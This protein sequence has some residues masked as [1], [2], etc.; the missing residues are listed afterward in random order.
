MFAPTFSGVLVVLSGD[1]VN[2]IF[3]IDLVTFVK[4]FPRDSC[5]GLDFFTTGLISQYQPLTRVIFS[6]PEIC[7]KILNIF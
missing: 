7:G 1:V 5:D 4:G 6:C 2:K 3:C